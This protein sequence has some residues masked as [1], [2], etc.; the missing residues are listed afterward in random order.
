MVIAWPATLVIV[1]GKRGMLCPGLV[2]GITVSVLAVVGRAALGRAL[3][4]DSNVGVRLAPGV[5]ESGATGHGGAAGLGE[6][7]GAVS[8]ETLSRRRG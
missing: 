2:D 1:S 4:I 7:P 5:G 6:Q 8:R 3:S